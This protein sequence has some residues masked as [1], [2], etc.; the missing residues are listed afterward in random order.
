MNNSGDPVHNSF[1]VSDKITEQHRYVP[2]QWTQEEFEAALPERFKTKQMIK[3]AVKLV[4]EDASAQD[5]C[6]N[7]PATSFNKSRKMENEKIRSLR[8]LFESEGEN[9]QHFRKGDAEDPNAKTN[10]EQNTIQIEELERCKNSEV[11]VKMNQADLVKRN[12]KEKDESKSTSSSCKTLQTECQDFNSFFESVLKCLLSI[13]SFVEVLSS[14][15]DANPIIYEFKKVIKSIENHHKPEFEKCVANFSEKLSEYQSSDELLLIL[16]LLIDTLRESDEIDENRIRRL[17]QGK[18]CH[19]QTCFICKKITT[20]LEPFFCLNPDNKTAEI[21]IGQSDS[22]MVSFQCC[23]YNGSWQIETITLPKKSGITAA[24]L[25]EEILKHP[26]FFN[27]ERDDIRIGLVRN[28]CIV[29]LLDNTKN[30][31]SI[32]ETDLFAFNVL[33]FGDGILGFE[34]SSD[35]MGKSDV[36]P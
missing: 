27:C 30:I 14:F 2:R 11:K 7:K 17:F 31:F 13:R 24:E 20:I 25:I 21:D 4:Q 6:M 22:L 8:A 29:S 1:K 12:D 23:N 3:N 15:S 34:N 9:L 26:E 19:T 28:G 32:Q 35:S 36:F 18:F 33:K 5:L 16:K 10:H